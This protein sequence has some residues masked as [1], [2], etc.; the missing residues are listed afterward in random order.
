MQDCTDIG[1]LSTTWA[2]LCSSLIVYCVF[3]STAHSAQRTE[4]GRTYDMGH[5]VDPRLSS[6]TQ[7]ALG[8]S[9]IAL[10]TACC[11][12]ACSHD[13]SQHLLVVPLHSTPP[14]CHL[15]PRFSLPFLCPALAWQTT[16]S[17]HPIHTFSSCLAFDSLVR[18]GQLFWGQA[19][20]RLMRRLCGGLDRFT[21][22]LGVAGENG[23]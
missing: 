14:T 3:P 16:T 12:P 2:Y 17:T 13:R 19:P 5:G 9:A 6:G 11:C 7:Y 20:P 15:A 4:G 10:V 22:Y 18:V 1:R 8:L 23:I 21:V